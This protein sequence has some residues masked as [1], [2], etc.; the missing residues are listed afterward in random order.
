MHP[1]STNYYATP[2]LAA[3]YDADCAGRRDLSFYI[4]LADELSAR[5]VADIGS[6]TGPSVQPVGRR[7]P[8]RHRG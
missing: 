3:A 5:R 7:G 6:G 4:G 2:E 8:R 1:E